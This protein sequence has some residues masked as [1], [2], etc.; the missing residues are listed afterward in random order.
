MIVF[1]PNGQDQFAR[2]GRMAPGDNLNT[3]LNGLSQTFYV[4][5]T[6]KTCGDL[7]L[8]YDVRKFVFDILFAEPVEVCPGDTLEYTIFNQGEGPLTYVWKPD[9]HIVANDSTVR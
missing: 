9:P 2:T 1:L 4:Q 7:V 3:T 5:F 6:D 8:S